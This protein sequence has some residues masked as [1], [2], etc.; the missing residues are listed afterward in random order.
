[1]T[2]K[3]TQGG[4]LSQEQISIASFKALLD[5]VEKVE[6]QNRLSIYEGVL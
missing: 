3:L 2:K 1:M 4:L 6:E 5:L